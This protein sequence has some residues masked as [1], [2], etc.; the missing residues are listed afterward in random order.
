MIIYRIYNL[1]RSFKLRFIFKKW[2][3]K[4]YCHLRYGVGTKYDFRNSMI[5]LINN[6]VYD[7]NFNLNTMRIVISD[8]PDN[9]GCS[10][11]NHWHYKYHNGKVNIYKKEE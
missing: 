1:I 3:K 8:S 7:G 11:T 5:Y 9:D 4:N 10:L 2:A 6:P